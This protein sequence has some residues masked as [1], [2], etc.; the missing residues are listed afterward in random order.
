MRILLYGLGLCL[1]LPAALYGALVWENNRTAPPPTEAALAAALEDGIQWLEQHQDSILRNQTAML[2]WM[3][4]QSAQRTQDPRLVAL[5][6]RYRRQVLE[7]N[8]SYLWQPLFDRDAWVPLRDESVKP[9]SYYY[10]LILHGL[11]CDAELGALPLVRE[12]MQAD[13]CPS[14]YPLRPACVTHQ[15]IGM[16]FMQERG[17]GEKAEV[18]QVVHSLQDRIARQLTWDPRPVDVYLQRVLMLVESGQVERVKPVWL[19]R[20]LDAQLDDGG[21]GDFHP[22]LPLGNGK[23]FGFSGRGVSIGTPDP[24]FHATAQGVLLLSLLLPGT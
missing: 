10:L 7:P 21:W 22:L 20:V 16:R 9:L 2:W 6:D 5:F 4:Q 19:Q 12:Q 23:H 3:V 18:D 14:R 8:P 13:F 15:T 17:C 1:L 24:S 11:T